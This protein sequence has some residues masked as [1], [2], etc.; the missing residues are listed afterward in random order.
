MYRTDSGT[1]SNAVYQNTGSVAVPVWTLLDTALPGDTASSL[2]DTNSV[3]ALDVGTTASA[4]NNFRVT[5][6]AAGAVSANALLLS[7]VGTDSAISIQVSP[8]GATG[9]LTLGL[10]TGTGDIVVGSS[11]T[12]QT[13]KIG[14]GAGAATVNIANV[15]T[16]GSTV[17][18]A[19]AATSAA[20]DTVNIATGIPITSGGKVVH[21]AD[22][23]PGAGTTVAVTI[24][25]GGTT[26]GTVGLTLG[27]VGAAAH[28]TL[29]QGG[30]G[31]GASAG[32][33]LTTAVAGDILIGNPAGAATITLGS[34]STTQIV[35]INGGA[36]V[37]T[38]NIAT[39]AAANVTKIGA[40]ASLTTLGGTVTQS[41]DTNRCTGSAAANA[42][43]ATLTDAAGVNVTVATG[44]R[45]TLTLAAGLQAGANTFNLNGHGTDSI[46]LSTNPAT[47]LST[48]Y[49]TG[50]VIDLLFNGTVWLAM[51]GQ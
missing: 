13:V 19:G 21:I 43:V 48:A 17:S 31:T 42:P 6:S 46:K 50:G 28:T 44:L 51:G 37:A 12:T 15:S 24:G 7:A 3:T 4:V 32:L 35:V 25:S 38:T 27:S 5:N 23:V 9:I 8:K 20:T 36:G 16:A 22:A 47:D 39:G 11:S 34:S 45:V 26:T 29:I 10:A 33:K 14:N 40:A 41:L 18:I 49:A 1:G 30:N 2:I